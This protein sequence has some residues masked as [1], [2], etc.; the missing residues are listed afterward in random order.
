MYLITLNNQCAKAIVP[1]FSSH[2]NRLRCEFFYLNEE[3]I[4]YHCPNEDELIS[5]IVTYNLGID[6]LVAN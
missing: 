1:S 2:L 6:V 5:L 3:F 4:V